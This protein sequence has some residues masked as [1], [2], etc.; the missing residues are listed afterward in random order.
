MKNFHLSQA[1]Q[2]SC[3]ILVSVILLVRLWGA[4]GYHDESHGIESLLFP[5]LI[6]AAT[7][8]LSV[9]S[10]PTVIKFQMSLI[11]LQNSPSST[12]INSL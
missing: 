7:Q 4:L 2:P 11:I 6:F 10:G 3:W 8:I 12:S 9:R 1:R 5:T